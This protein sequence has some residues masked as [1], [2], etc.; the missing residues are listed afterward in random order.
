MKAMLKTFVVLVVLVGF[1]VLIGAASAQFSRPE[2]AI[3]YRKSVMFIIAQH[4][5]RLGAMVKGAKPYDQ[6]TFAHN[7]AI[8]E[9]LSALP[10]EAFLAAGSDRGDTTMNSRVLR[11]PTEFRDIA[12]G[13]RTE[14]GRLISAANGDDFDAVKRQFGAVGKSCKDCHSQF[15]K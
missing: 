9:T 2:D 5:S 11:N 7:A 13:F 10:W 1:C 3:K 6:D 8:V 12:Q 15:R 4:F 14:I